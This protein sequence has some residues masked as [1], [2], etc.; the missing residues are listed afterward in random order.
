MSTAIGPAAM[1][2]VPIRPVLGVSIAE[3]RRQWGSRVVFLVTSILVCPLMV[4]PFAANG[5]DDQLWGNRRLG[6]CRSYNPK[7]CTQYAD[8]RIDI[9]PHPAFQS[10]P[11]VVGQ[12]QLGLGSPG[13]CHPAT[14]HIRTE[15]LTQHTSSALLGCVGVGALA[16]V[17]GAG[18]D[19]QEGLEFAEDGVE[20]QAG[21]GAFGS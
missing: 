2:R 10:R 7:F 20:G 5:A 3:L 17:A 18:P 14:L 16:G 19:G 8:L 1:I 11:L 21:A 9:W 6:P 4:P 15:F 12:D 13:P